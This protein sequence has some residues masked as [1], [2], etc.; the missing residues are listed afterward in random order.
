VA[1]TGN[2]RAIIFWIFSVIA[3]IS[4]V[5]LETEIYPPASGVV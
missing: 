2:A 5:D 3:V 1:L 4:L